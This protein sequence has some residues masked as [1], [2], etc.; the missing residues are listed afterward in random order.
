MI[1]KQT[2]YAI[3]TCSATLLC[4][5]VMLILNF[6]IFHTLAFGDELTSR[7][8]TELKEYVIIGNRGTKHTYYI[9][10][11]YNRPIQV[12]S[13][14][15]N[16]SSTDELKCK[17]GSHTFCLLTSVNGLEFGLPDHYNN[18]FGLYFCLSL[19]VICVIVYPFRYRVY[20]GS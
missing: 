17:I 13:P 6:K 20:K 3:F 10:K 5:L 11:L 14:T 12:I 7:I 19:F 4:L 9:A 1:S 2:K 16:L 15:S 8:E 18:V